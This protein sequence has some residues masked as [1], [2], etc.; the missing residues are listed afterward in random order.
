MPRLRTRETPQA[1]V[2]SLVKVARAEFAANGFE[3]A[4]LN[5]IL[6]GAGISKGAFYYHYDSKGDLFQATVM[7]TLEP[8]ARAAGRPDVADDVDAFWSNLESYFGRI[9]VL[10]CD[11]PDAMAL[12]RAAG[13]AMGSPEVLGTYQ[14]V[15]NRVFAAVVEVIRNGQQVGAIRDDLPIEV[16]AGLTF[17]IGQ[18]VDAHVLSAWDAMEES[19][20]DGWIGRTVDLFRRVAEPLDATTEGA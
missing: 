16:L 3:G 15:Q 18:V 2:E 4:S 5:K 7:H 11:D 6:E 13:Q 14:E 19:E 1:L 8:L 20:R 10:M 17:G 12:M 9:Y